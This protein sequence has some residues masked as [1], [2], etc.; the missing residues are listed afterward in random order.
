[1]DRPAVDVY[2][3]A[4]RGRPERPLVP[5]PGGGPRNLPGAAVSLCPVHLGEQPAGLRKGDGRGRV[6]MKQIQEDLLRGHGF[7]S[8]A[9]MLAL[10]A[11]V[12]HANDSFLLWRRNDGSKAGLLY[13]I[14]RQQEADRG[15]IH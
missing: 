1:M 2:L 7:E 11:S 14:E 8:L 15:A 9:E 13:V 3:R 12:P 4:Y 10:V 6:T 5:G